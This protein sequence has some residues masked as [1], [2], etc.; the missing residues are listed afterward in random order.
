MT[1]KILTKVFWET[2]QKVIGTSHWGRMVDKL[3]AEGYHI[4]TSRH[5]SLNKF[6]RIAN[7]GIDLS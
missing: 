6:Y 7:K 2:E 4:T 5:R 3:E 1:Q